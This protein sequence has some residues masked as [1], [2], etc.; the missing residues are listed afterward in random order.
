MLVSYDP[1][2]GEIVE[3]VSDPVHPGFPEVWRNAG[4]TFIE[5]DRSAFV[6][7]GVRLP[8]SSCCVVDGKIATKPVD[9]KATAHAAA[10]REIAV[11]SEQ[12]AASGPLPIHA[13]KL[14]AALSGRHDL[15][16]GEAASRG[17][18]TEE[19]AQ[20]IITKAGESLNAEADYQASIKA[21]RNSFEETA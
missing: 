15:L 14:Q 20:I 4:K 6:F 2:T 13:M 19:L 1:Q 10:M 11:L 5:C 17:I 12:R 7:E 3:T 18:T 16:E 8:M 9:E 21:I